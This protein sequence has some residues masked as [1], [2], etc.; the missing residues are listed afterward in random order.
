MKF[1]GQ[2]RKANQKVKEFGVL[3]LLCTLPHLGFKSFHP[4]VHK[5][6]VPKEKWFKKITFI[7]L[8]SGSGKYPGHWN[9]SRTNDHC[10]KEYLIKERLNG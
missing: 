2:V 3:S 1:S 10:A 5:Y 8:K 6:C 7:L 4:T 9:N